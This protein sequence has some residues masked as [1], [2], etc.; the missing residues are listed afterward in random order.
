APIAH[1]IGI[2]VG[3]QLGFPQLLAGCC[4]ESAEAP[5]VRGAHEDEAA[6]RNGRARAA[7]I[8]DEALAL[9]QLVHHAERDRPRDRAGIGVDGHELAPRRLVAR[10]LRA[11]RTALLVVLARQRRAEREERALSVDAGAVIGL[12]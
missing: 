6:R 2:R 12:V 8:A 1:R 9:W 5:V 7:G 3:A 11:L 4:I 10:G